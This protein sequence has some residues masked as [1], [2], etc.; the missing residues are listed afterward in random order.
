MAS[1][2]CGAFRRASRG[3]SGADGAELGSGDEGVE[4]LSDD[5][6]TRGIRDL[7]ERKLLT[8]RRVP[9]GDDWHYDRLRNTYSI[10]MRR[11]GDSPGGRKKRQPQPM[12][13]PNPF[14]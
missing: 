9:I 12:E 2:G 3:T 10:D 6:W 11:L 1:A 13:P 4:G 14:S 7:S 5:T 8:V